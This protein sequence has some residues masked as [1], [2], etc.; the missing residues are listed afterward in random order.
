[1]CR[2]MTYE[3]QLRSHPAYFKAALKAIDLYLRIS[4]DPSLTE[5][6]LSELSHSSMCVVLLIK[7]PGR[8]GR[9]EKGRK[10]GPKSRAKGEEGSCC[11]IGREE[12]RPACSG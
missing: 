8:G 5:E 9:T 12:G 11:G 6:K 10:E 4:D 3:D 2:L 1:M 7:S